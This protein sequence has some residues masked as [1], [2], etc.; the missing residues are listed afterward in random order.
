MHTYWWCMVCPEHGEYVHTAKGE[1]KGLGTALRHTEDT[2]HPT[3]TS[4]HPRHAAERPLP[5]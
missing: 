4:I 3:M 5:R 1:M 2:S